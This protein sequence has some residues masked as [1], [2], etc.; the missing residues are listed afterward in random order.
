MLLH[1]SFSLAADSILQAFFVLVLTDILPAAE[2]SFLVLY[3]ESGLHYG[4]WVKK[5]LKKLKENP[6]YEQNLLSTY[7]PLPISSRPVHSAYKMPTEYSFHLWDF[8]HTIL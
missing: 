4:L 5:F 1:I 7:H 6:V 3:L 8:A 2:Q